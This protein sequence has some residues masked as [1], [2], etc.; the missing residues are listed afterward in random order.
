MNK[1]YGDLPR[2]VDTVKVNCHEMMSYQYMPIKMAGQYNSVIYE[3]RIYCFH[4]LINLATLDFL[5][6][7]GEDELKEHYIYIT[8]KHGYV[9]PIRS[10][11]RKGYHSDGF[12]TDDINYIWCDRFPTVFNN[13]AFN[14]TLDDNTSIKEME[15]QSIANNEFSYPVNSLLCLDQYNIHRVADIDGCGMRTFVKVS[16][17]KDRYNLIGNSRNYLIDYDWVMKPRK[18]SRNIPQSNPD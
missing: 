2:L 10:F 5:D 7:F 9:S 4:N 17:S 3:D 12:M 13:T 14:L 15:D 11:N 6:K 8:A 16:F 1:K 18:E